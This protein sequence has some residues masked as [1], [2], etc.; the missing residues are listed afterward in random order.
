MAW[1]VGVKAAEADCST[2][3]RMYA[4]AQQEQE[5][6]QHGDPAAQSGDEEKA[7]RYDAARA[8]DVE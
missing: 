8:S 1:N 5:W 4:Q 7:A 6:E 2:K 3:I